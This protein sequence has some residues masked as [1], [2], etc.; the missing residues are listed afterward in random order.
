VRIIRPWALQPQK[1]VIFGVVLQMFLPVSSSHVTVFIYSHNL[2]IPI[3][4]GG[5]LAQDSHYEVRE[6]LAALSM[7]VESISRI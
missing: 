6:G 7:Q 3:N 5:S 4:M 1:L 2:P